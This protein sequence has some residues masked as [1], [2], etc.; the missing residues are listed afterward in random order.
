LRYRRLVGA[1]GIK[2]ALFILLGLEYRY[3]SGN[4]SCVHFLCGHKAYSVQ[5]PVIITSWN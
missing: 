5:L 1:K 4:S 2:L 3:V